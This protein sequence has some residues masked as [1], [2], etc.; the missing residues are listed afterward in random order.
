MTTARA[1][2][3]R[4]TSESKQ[5]ILEAAR[6]LF[7]E[8]GYQRTT[9]RMIAERAGVDPSLAI[10]FFSSKEHLFAASMPAPS[11]E[12]L[13]APKLMAALPRAEAARAISRRILESVNSPEAS[14]IL[15][16]MRAASSKPEAVAQLREIFISRMMLP[17]MTELGLS[18]PKERA[19]LLAVIVT[20][21]SFLHEL[22]EIKEE[23]PDLEENAELALLAQA[24]EL[25]LTTDLD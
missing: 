2:R 7:A 11:E 23:W 6:S 3:R 12:A 16:M 20:G 22:L 21:M 14:N 1:G 25:V 24:I 18:R 4:G 17:M 13:A 5:Q 19:V 10:Y 8:R 15:G 9:M